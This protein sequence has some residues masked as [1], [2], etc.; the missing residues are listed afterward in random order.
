MLLNTFLATILT[1][2]AQSKTVKQEACPELPHS[3]E[4]A[5]QVCLEYKNKFYLNK[6]EQIKECEKILQLSESTCR[7]SVEYILKV[8]DQHMQRNEKFSSKCQNGILDKLSHLL[9]TTSASETDT[10]NYCLR[11]IQKDDTKKG[12]HYQIRTIDIEPYSSDF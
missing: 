9:I 11:V 3:V 12:F 4:Q 8:N 5:A 1:I 2:Y 7:E 6:K 10:Y